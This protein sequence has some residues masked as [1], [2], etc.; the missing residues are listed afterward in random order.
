MT[1]TCLLSSQDSTCLSLSLG[2]Q[3]QRAFWS[4][5]MG[6]SKCSSSM[7]KNRSSSFVFA[8][9]FS[10]SMRRNESLSSHFKRG[11]GRWSYLRKTYHQITERREGIE[12]KINRQHT[13]RSSGKTFSSSSIGVFLVALCGVVDCGLPSACIPRQT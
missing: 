9:W 1:S 7:S 5:T 11:R 13:S 2:F 6:C 12:T 10:F 4:K 8:S 3:S